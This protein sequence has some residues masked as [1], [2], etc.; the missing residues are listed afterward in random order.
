MAT[1]NFNDKDMS[2]SDQFCKLP[3]VIFGWQR[4]QEEESCWV[5]YILLILECDN[6]QSENKGCYRNTKK[7][8]RAGEVI[9]L[10]LVGGT[11]WP[12]EGYGGERECVE[13]FKR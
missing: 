9:A 10:V 4:V 13:T 8:D 2:S 11:L 1:G 6:T 12:G 7:P 3:L 5:L